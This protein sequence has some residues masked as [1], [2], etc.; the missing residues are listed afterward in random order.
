MCTYGIVLREVTRLFL[1][2][3]PSR[4]GGFSARFAGVVVPG[5][6]IRVRA[7]REDDRLLVSAAVGERLVLA[8]CVL[9]PA[10]G[11]MLDTWPPPTGSATG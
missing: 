8:G 10:W 11:V 7:W 1:D 3:D 6:T 5:E 2:G 9:A 4:V